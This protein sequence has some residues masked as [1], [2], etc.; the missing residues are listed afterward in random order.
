MNKNCNEHTSNY[1]HHGKKG[2]DNAILVDAAQ[3]LGIC[4]AHRWELIYC[5]EHESKDVQM[6]MLTLPSSGFAWN[7]FPVVTKDQMLLSTGWYTEL[8]L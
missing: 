4:C 3:G 6:E 1:I 7:L 8:L 2:G 5:T